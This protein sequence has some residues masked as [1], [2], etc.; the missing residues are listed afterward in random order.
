[1]NQTQSDRA[2]SS[3]SPSCG[4][5]E[6]LWTADERLTSPYRWKFFYR[7]DAAST[8]GPALASLRGLDHAGIIRQANQFGFSPIPKRQ[9]DIHLQWIAQLDT[10]S[11]TPIGGRALREW[12]RFE[13][14]SLWHF[15]PECCYL[16]SAAAL[17]ETIELIEY[18]TDL[19]ER[20]RPSRLVVASRWNDHQRAVVSLISRRYR[21]PAE[22][23]TLESAQP[24]APEPPRKDN[25]DPHYRSLESGQSHAVRDYVAGL[26]KSLPAPVIG[27]DPVLLVSFPRAWTQT[28]DRG[29]IDIYF[30]AFRSFFQERGLSPIRVDVPYYFQME[31]GV[32]N[33]I[34]DH[35]QDSSNPY[36]TIFLDEYGTDAIWKSALQG[37]SEL[38]RLFQGWIQDPDFHQALSWKGIS[39]VTPLV[40]FWQ[41]IFV[42][43]LAVRCIPAM[44]TA[45]RMLDAIRPRA[46]LLS[47]ETGS[48]A[49]AILIEAHR[50]GI[51]SLGLQHAAILP[52]HEYYLHDDIVHR[53]DLSQESDGR[54]VC[55]RTLLFGPDAQRIL[56]QPGRYPLEATEVL[57]CDYR[58]LVRGP[59]DRELLRRLKSQWSPSGRKIVLV[60]GQ[61]SLTYGLLNQ[62]IAKLSPSEYSVLIKLHPADK[63]GPDYRDWMEDRGFEVSVIRDFLPEAIEAAELVFALV[64]ST[65]GLESLFAGKPVF[66]LRDLDLP[67]TVPWERFTTDLASV[68]SIRITEQTPQQKIELQRTLEDLGYSQNW[69]L[70]D[71]HLRLH[72]I[73]DSLYPKDPAM[74]DDARS[75]HANNCQSF[76][77]GVPDPSPVRR[78]NPFVVDVSDYA[79]AVSVVNRELQAGR[80]LNALDVCEQI[81]DAHPGKAAAFLAVVYDLLKSQPNFK[82]RFLYQSRFF[83]FGIQPGWKVL[84][85]GSGHDPFPM[86]THLADRAIQDNQLGR[87]GAPFKALQGRPVFECSVEKMPFSDKEFDFV[88]CSHVLEHVED[89]DQ[90]CRELMRVARRG[91]I[92]TPT[93]GKDLFFDYARV[94][95]HR[96]AVEWSCDRLVFN[97]YTPRQIQGLSCDLL[98]QFLENPQSDREKAFSA[99][100]FL[101]ADRINTMLLWQDQFAF[102]VRRPVRTAASGVESGVY[103]SGIGSSGDSAQSQPSVSAESFQTQ[104]TVSAV[105]PTH[106]RAA[107]LPRAIQSVLSQTRPVDE[108]V[109]ADDGST[110]DTESLIA[111]MRSQYPKIRYIRLPQNGGAQRARNAGIRA[112]SGEWIAFLDSDDVWLPDRIRLCLEKA[113]QM[114]VPAVHTEA[115]MRRNGQL[116]LMK[117]SS[118][119]GYIFP[120]LL[121]CPGPTFPGLMVRKECLLRVGLLDESLPAWQEWDAFLRLSQYF[122]FG[123]VAEPCFVW[124]AHENET[125]SKDK[126]RD[127]A[128]YERIVATWKDQILQ[129]AGPEALEKHFQTIARKRAALSSAIPESSKMGQAQMRDVTRATTIV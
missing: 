112:A 114:N 79:A 50:R 37:Q 2:G 111:R 42:E 103:V 23:I 91:Y 116:S 118:A 54:I 21:I 58:I 96:W 93:P 84:D 87:G 83:D 18:L 13:G 74:T 107:Y 57:G 60:L 82:S 106:N 11:R 122:K 24:A 26:R 31:C 49:Q 99:L 27:K 29:R 41:K 43:H 68:D 77:R 109:I 67:Y 86:A 95:N 80:L 55:T 117:R 46:I 59:A 88:F 121:K 3:G 94:S 126:S 128:G 64:S 10:I 105:I 39:L 5:L 19:I 71:F 127:L 81:A 12:L 51:P 75:G 63:S 17:Q 1:M 113:R 108:I 20:F 119:Q 35:L 76:I 73:F 70:K 45:R 85:I 98:N 9:R 66:T 61:P 40:S 15:I 53:P 44:L 129:F 38:G 69:T 30:E 92:E 32:K 110:D 90:A 22:C 36:P 123:Y 97:Q 47:Y 34:D 104:P 115:Y 65:A 7:Y 89:P 124:D 56:T 102:E 4:A 33:Y 14:V 25:P 52:E 125:I 120:D 8:A 101:K 78:R 6:V 72:S 16:G 48:Y 62:A 28:T 100:M